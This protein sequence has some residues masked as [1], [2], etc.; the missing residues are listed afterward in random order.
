MV[1][2]PPTRVW[3]GRSL[4][5]LVNINMCW[6]ECSQSMLLY[7][8]SPLKTKCRYIILLMDEILHHLEWLK[9]Y[10]W[11]ENHHPWWCRILS[12]N[13]MPVPWIRNGLFSQPNSSLRQKKFRSVAQRLSKCVCLLHNLWERW[14]FWIWGWFFWKTKKIGWNE[15]G[16]LVTGV[17]FPHLSGEGC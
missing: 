11:W 7:H 15:F 1:K 8:I 4:N 9:P 17:F 6:C 13:S 12:I 2:W 3:K 16:G 10:K 5:H 14:F